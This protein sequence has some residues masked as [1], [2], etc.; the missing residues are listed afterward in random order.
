MQTPICLSDVDN[1]G[2]PGTV[3]GVDF[4]G[5]VVKVGKNV[6]SR[7]VGDHVAGCVHGGCFEDEGAFAEYIK[8]PADLVWFVPENTLSHDE[9]ATLNCACVPCTPGGAPNE[10]ER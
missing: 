3:L 10:Y 7:K 8:T 6:S 4:S 9:A 1:N 5:N 2:K